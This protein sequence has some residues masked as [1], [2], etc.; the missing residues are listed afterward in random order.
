[1]A[2]MQSASST[3]SLCFMNA[4]TI[5][6][7][8]PYNF[9]SNIITAARHLICRK[10]RRAGVIFQHQLCSSCL[11]QKFIELEIEPKGPTTQMPECFPNL[12]S[13]ILA[14]TPTLVRESD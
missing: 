12:G 3:R 1:M 9:R 14:E 10:N 13:S 6:I 2:S 8:Y 4:P 7:S 5:A 11:F